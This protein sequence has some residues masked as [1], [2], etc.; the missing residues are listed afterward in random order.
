MSL[1]AV[2]VCIPDSINLHP[3]EYTSDTLLSLSAIKQSS[4]VTSADVSYGDAMFSEPG[5]YFGTIQLLG[6]IPLK[7]VS[8]NVLPKISV[9][10]G[11]N[12]IGIKM[13]TDGILT[14][15][16]SYVIDKNGVKH[17]PAKDAGLKEGDR[18]IAINNVPL[19]T[20]EQMGQLINSE[21]VN[22]EIRREDETL[23]LEIKAVKSGEDNEY[24]IGAWIRDSSAGVGT[25]T[26]YDPENGRY[27]ALGHAIKD[28]DTDTVLQV[29]NGSIIDCNIE[30]V[31]KGE[32]GTPGELRG[33]FGSTTIGSIVKNCELGIY[34]ELRDLSCIQGCEPMEIMPKHEV[35]TGA[36][37]ILSNAVGNKIESYNIEIQKVSP[38]SSNKGMIIKITDPALL[39][40]TGGIVQGMSGSPI[41]QDGKL[42]GAVTHVFVNDPTRGYGVFIEN[43]LTE[44]DTIQ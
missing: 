32:K 4:A 10:P 19:S 36:A 38:F 20:T 3:G 41:I 26:F 22:L 18:I 5:Q 13:F 16:I 42:V 17:T 25:V 44:T 34:G 23:N 1:G 30:S 43:M 39:E 14:V 24:K 8:V 37:Q 40:K 9:I 6:R 15:G 33:V 35:K 11:G 29:A 27:A 21:T 12:T 31:K 7:N 28:I 2:S